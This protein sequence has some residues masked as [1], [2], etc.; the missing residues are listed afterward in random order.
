MNTKQPMANNQ[1]FLWR[2]FQQLRHHG[3]P[4]SP[5]DYQ[6]LRETLSLDATIGWP[7]REA[8]LA[9]CRALWTKSRREREILEALFER[10]VPVWQIASTE[11]DEA[12]PDDE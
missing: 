4:L 5:T 7:S 12:L 6:T 8:L 11:N 9:L 3:F 2:L 10:I 1:S